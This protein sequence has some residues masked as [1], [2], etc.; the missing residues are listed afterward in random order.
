MIMIREERKGK[1]KVEK[2][3]SPRESMDFL[4]KLDRENCNC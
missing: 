3:K 2:E 1:D 4:K